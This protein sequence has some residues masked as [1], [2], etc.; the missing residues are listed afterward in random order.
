MQKANFHTQENHPIGELSIETVRNCVVTPSMLVMTPFG[1]SRAAAYPNLSLS[2]RMRWNAAGLGSLLRDRFR[3]I[4][5]SK[6]YFSTLTPWSNNYFHWMTEAAPKF[7]LFSEELSKG[8]IIV[9]KGLLRSAHEFLELFGFNNLLTVEE[10]I[11]FGQLKVVSNPNTNHYLPEHIRLVRES[12]IQKI[13]PEPA[14]QRRR[15]YVSR[16]HARGRR[17]PN[18][19]ELLKVIA[20][21][22]F[23]CVYL[24][25]ATLKDQVNMFS[26]CEILISI[27]GAALTNAIFMPAGSSLVEIYPSVSDPVRDLSR[28]FSRL[29]RLIDVDHRFLFSE[30]RGNKKTA[31]LDSDDLIADPRS[32]RDLILSISRPIKRSVGS[33]AY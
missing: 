3:R 14:R 21:L 26:N 2:K 9:P 6:T 1:L 18:E 10:N 30:R 12:L 17:V 23:E 16:K 8:T 4:S 24:E 31:D 32:V 33:G 27:H 7:L 13:K 20:D 29:C 19:E 22:G 15:I 28:C 5:D 11:A 25:D